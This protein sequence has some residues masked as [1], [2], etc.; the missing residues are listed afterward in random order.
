MIVAVRIGPSSEA[1]VTAAE[2]VAGSSER[3]VVVENDMWPNNRP[4]MSPEDEKRRWRIE[5]KVVPEI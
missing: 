3:G 1:M 4:W 5:A 2:V